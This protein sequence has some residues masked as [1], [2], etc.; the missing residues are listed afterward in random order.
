MILPPK[1]PDPILKLTTRQPLARTRAGKA[2]HKYSLKTKERTVSDAELERR[3]AALFTREPPPAPPPRP[4]R[5]VI[6]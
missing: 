6:L 3:E 1:R 5:R 2:L 4:P